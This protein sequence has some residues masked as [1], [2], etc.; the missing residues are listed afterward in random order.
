MTSPFGRPFVPV[1]I[2]SSVELPTFEKVLCKMTVG[3]VV[4][5][6]TVE[7]RIEVEDDGREVPILEVI[8]VFVELDTPGIVTAGTPA[9]PA[10]PRV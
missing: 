2:A 5:P 9:T 1:G 8:R 6:V 7:R 4:T 3:V 10:H